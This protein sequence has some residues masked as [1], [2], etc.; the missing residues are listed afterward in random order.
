LGDHLEYMAQPGVTPE[1]QQPVKQKQIMDRKQMKD[2][3]IKSRF[4]Q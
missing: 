3:M 2:K 4:T 1:K